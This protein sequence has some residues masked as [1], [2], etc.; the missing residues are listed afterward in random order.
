MMRTLQF[1]V[2]FAGGFVAGALLFG[3][4]NRSSATPIDTSYCFLAHH[5]D[6]FSNRQILTSA[7]IWIGMHGMALVDDSGCSDGALSFTA[8]R[9]ISGNVD[10]LNAKLRVLEPLHELPVTLVG[11]LHVGSR[12]ENAYR[13][14]RYHMGFSIRP[15]PEFIIDRVVS[16]GEATQ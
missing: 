8:A 9:N 12:I 10:E 16:V 1:L 3:R 14:L 13:W 7:Q 2:L 4:Q 11:T 6:L 15:E 5:I